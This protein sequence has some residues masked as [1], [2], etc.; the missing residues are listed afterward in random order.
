MLDKIPQAMQVLARALAQR[1]GRQPD[2][3]TVR[4]V[5]GAV[6]GAAVAVSAAVT[7]DAGADLPAL[8]DQAIAH[9]EPCLA[10]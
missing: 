3:L 9:L 7:D 1:A 2:D 8:I 6:V 4:A 5:A 10:L